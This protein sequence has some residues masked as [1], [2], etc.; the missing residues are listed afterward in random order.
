MRYSIENVEYAVAMLNAIGTGYRIRVEQVLEIM[1]QMV[2]EDYQFAISFYGLS[3]VPF[4]D[5]SSIWVFVTTHGNSENDTYNILTPR[6]PEVM[7]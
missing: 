7:H 1:Q 4:V 2:D 6:N 5:I 3:I